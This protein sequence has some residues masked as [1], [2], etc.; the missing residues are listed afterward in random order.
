[1]HEKHVNN[2]DPESFSSLPLR[3]KNDVDGG[4]DDEAVP[5]DRALI[6]KLKYMFVF[7]SGAKAHRLLNDSCDGFWSELWNVI[8]V[9]L[10]D[11]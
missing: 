7:I 4:D 9:G 11:R 2:D 1:M 6:S 10:S 8:I 5:P 3:A